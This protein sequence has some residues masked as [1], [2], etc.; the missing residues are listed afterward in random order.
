LNQRVGTLIGTEPVR[1]PFS[2]FD[3]AFTHGPL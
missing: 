1:Q 3:R 2:D